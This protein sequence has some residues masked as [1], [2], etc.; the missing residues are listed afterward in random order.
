MSVVFANLSQATTEYCSVVTNLT[1]ANSTHNEQVALYSNRL[2]NNEV[3]NM[4]LQT[5]IRKLQGETN[6]LKA[7]VA[8][9][10]KS[11][12]SGGA[13]TANKDKSRLVPKWEI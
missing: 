4:A 2:S 5:A 8:I 3:D 11:G 12:H 7:E 10:K 6:N 1:M 13:G 9:L